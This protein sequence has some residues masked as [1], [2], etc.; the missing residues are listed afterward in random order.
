M[1]LL[2]LPLL[3]FQFPPEHETDSPC[4]IL[5]INVTGDIRLEFS[6]EFFQ[7]KTAA[8]E[9]ISFCERRNQEELAKFFEALIVD[10]KRITP[11]PLKKAF[12]FTRFVLKT[13][14]VR[15][16][17]E[18]LKAGLDKPFKPFS[19]KRT[20]N[21]ILLLDVSSKLLASPQ[22]LI[23]TQM[24]WKGD[25]SVVIYRQTV[26]LRD[27]FECHIRAVELALA[28]KTM[29]REFLINLFKRVIVLV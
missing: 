19:Q 4:L 13:E 25:F 27:V 20:L 3:V 23:T 29:I 9:F 7:S 24:D 22:P 12:P 6:D 26:G 14:G 18:A 2:D 11:L 8:T 15:E 10:A 17:F 28:I 16:F 1:G 5:T 21:N